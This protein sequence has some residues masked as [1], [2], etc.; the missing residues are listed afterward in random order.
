V[1]MYREAACEETG[2]QGGYAAL[3][4]ARLD[5]E[6]MQKQGLVRKRTLSPEDLQEIA[7]LAEL[8][9]QHDGIMVRLNWE[10]LR[11]RTGH[12]PNDFFYYED[13]N[14]LGYLALYSFSPYEA[15]LTGMVHPE[16]RRQGIFY[17][18][19]RLANQELKHRR[20]PQ[21]LL[22]FDRR[23]P[24][25]QAFARAV[26]ARYRHSEY[27]M[28]RE[29]GSPPPTVALPEGV[30]IRPAR[31]DEARLLTHITAVAFEMQEDS[32]LLL[33]TTR[34]IMNPRR[35]TLV[36]EVAGQVVGLIRYIDGEEEAFIY[37]FC[38]LPEHQGH[39][40]GRQ[41]LAWTVQHIL[42]RRP[43]RIALEV[44]TTNE[45]ALSLYRSCGFEV[46]TTFDYYEVA[47]F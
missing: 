35:V 2:T 9:Q 47:V 20:V 46:T 27:R 42:S 30:R 22:F 39:G 43:R 37:G 5:R 11:A 15:E 24:G 17:T 21:I 14:L 10:M 1:R 38:M 23:S 6:G 3:L 7:A 33:D 19:F 32:A 40:Y 13:G 44:D 41:T 25:G 29:E 16:R 18:L 28:L 36:T 4:T 8:C 26:N 31:P 12:L 45:G 34:D